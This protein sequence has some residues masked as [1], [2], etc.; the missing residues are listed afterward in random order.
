MITGKIAGIRSRKQPNTNISDENNH[1]PFNLPA[2]GFM[3]NQT[4][5]KYNVYRA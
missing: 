2:H 5:G 1:Y 4:T 3:C